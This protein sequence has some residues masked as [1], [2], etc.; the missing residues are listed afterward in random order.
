MPRKAGNQRRYFEFALWAAGLARPPSV[1][2]VE[3]WFQVTRESAWRIHRNWTQAL[4]AHQQQAGGKRSATP[5]SNRQESP[6][7][8]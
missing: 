1:K 2:D 8:E 3:G 7:H 5:A 6:T 4:G